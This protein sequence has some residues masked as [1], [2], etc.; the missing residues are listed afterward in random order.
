MSLSTSSSTSPSSK[1]CTLTPLVLSRWEQTKEV[2]VRKLTRPTAL[3]VESAVGALSPVSMAM[4]KNPVSLVACGTLE[5]ASE[6]LRRASISTSALNAEVGTGTRSVGVRSSR[7]SDSASPGRPRFLRSIIWSDGVRRI[8]PTALGTE[9]DPPIPGAPPEAFENT[10][11]VSTVVTNP[12]LFRVVTPINISLFRRLL[13][14][15]PN[16]PLVESV[17]KG[18]VDG[19]WPWSR[20]VPSHPVTFDGSKAARSDVER[21]FL[22]NCRDDEIAAGRFSRPFPAL[23]PGMHAIPVH[24]VP[25]PCSEKLRLI[26]DFS[27]GDCSRNSTISR[28]DTNS[29]RL[30]GIRELADH[31]R[32]LRR[33]LGPD[34]D[35]N[36]FKSDVKGAFKILPMHLLWQPWQVY[37]IGDDYHVDRAATF[38][39]SASPPPPYMLSITH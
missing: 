25:K 8:S 39:S 37:K 5:S 38:G 22:E 14:L 13:A 4:T 30:D 15:H 18:F 27:A 10:D 29:T 19:F 12:S 28:D 26:T 34:A 1:L 31:L 16:R 32:C 2:G 24:A 17:C 3:E 11:L 35:I 36:V 33:E 7:A 23:L 9:Y 6:T 21:S 20:P